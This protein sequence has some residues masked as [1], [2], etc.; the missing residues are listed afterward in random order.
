MSSDALDWDHL[1]PSN[2]QRPNQLFKHLMLISL[3]VNVE[4]FLINIL[5]EAPGFLQQ[6]SF[7]T[8][9]IRFDFR[10]D[11]GVFIRLH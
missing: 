5:N 1:I 7:A 10:H 8:F 2:Y 3:R 6:S 11:F 4:I 9:L